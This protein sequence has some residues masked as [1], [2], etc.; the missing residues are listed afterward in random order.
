[1]KIVPS[2]PLLVLM[3]GFPGS[4]KTYFGRQF[5]EIFSAAHVQDD[6]VRYEL[7]ENPAYSADENRIVSSLMN[8]MTTEFLNAGMSVV[9]DAHTLRIAQRRA[10]RNLAAKLGAETLV[11]W[12]QIDEES[13]FTRA[14]KRDR[15]KADDRFSMPVDRTTFESFAEKMQHPEE[16]ELYV[17]VSGKHVFSTQKGTVL[18]KLRE[19]GLINTTDASGQVVKPGLVNLIPNPMAGRVDM[20]RRNVIIR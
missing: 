16:K 7:F 20:K 4:G 6:R 18:R 13:S 10:L 19:V 12:M 1:M 3:Y 15:R 11:V 2:K 5:C 8:Y 9:Y 17:V 14:N